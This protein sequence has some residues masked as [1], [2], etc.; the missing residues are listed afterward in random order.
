VVCNID[1]VR[2]T[3]A[4]PRICA[5][6]LAWARSPGVRAHGAVHWSG[7]SLTLQE[8]VGTPRGRMA[9]EPTAPQ[10]PGPLSAL[11]SRPAFWVVAVALLAALPL[12]RALRPEAPLPASAAPPSVVA[13][14]PG[15]L[16][17][18]GTVPDF[19]FT[20]SEGRPFKSSGLLGKVWVA[21]LGFTRCTRDCPAIARAMQQLQ[22]RSGGLG[23]AFQLVSFTVDPDYD[24][25][26]VLKAYAASL[27]AGVRW[28]FLTADR[29]DLEA[30]IIAGLQQ[31]MDKKGDDP[32]SISHGEQLV[33]VDQRH[34][35]RGLYPAE[36]EG[37]VDQVLRDAARLLNEGQP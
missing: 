17:V 14:V 10:P 25:P 18:L 4:F 23:D 8:R 16:P 36:A 21:S 13:A 19:V 15:P 9:T 22:G 26:S 24:L 34:Q 29:A 30:V 37:A 20:D 6:T 31:P 28:H 3:C 1:A 33:L 7:Q 32:M 11:V 27:Q 35:V 12:W 2:D 5:P